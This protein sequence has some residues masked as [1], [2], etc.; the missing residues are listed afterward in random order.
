VF[1]ALYE[2]RLDIRE[3]PAVL[4]RLRDEGFWL[5]DAVDEPINKKTRPERRQVIRRAM[6]RLIDRCRE[7]APE[8]GVIVCHGLVYE[9]AAVPLRAAGINVLHDEPLGNWRE[10]FASPSARRWLGPGCHLPSAAAGS[11]R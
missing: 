8:R 1:K 7:L 10:A 2:R 6:P 5:I 11:R 3:K 4:A 9:V